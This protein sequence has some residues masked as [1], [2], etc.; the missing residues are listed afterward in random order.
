[1]AKPRN[2]TGDR[3]GIIC[4]N[5]SMFITLIITSTLAAALFIYP[6]RN[7]RETPASRTLFL[8]SALVSWGAVVMWL[9]VSAAILGGWAALP[10]TDGE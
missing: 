5:G 7:L 8:A 10:P 2:F 4:Y 6:F 3:A 1:M 9:T